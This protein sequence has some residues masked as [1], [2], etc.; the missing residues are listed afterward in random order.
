[1]Y[2]LKPVNDVQLSETTFPLYRLPKLIDLQS[3]GEVKEVNMSSFSSPEEAADVLLGKLTKLDASLQKLEKQFGVTPGC[4]PKKVATGTY[5][6]GLKSSGPSTTV[7]GVQDIVISAN[8]AN[9]PLS[10]L[11]LAHQLSQQYKT[12]LSSYT[13]STAN[14]VNDKLRQ[15]FGS[16]SNSS[17]DRINS[18][19][20]VSIVWRNDSA[21]KWGPSLV[22]SAL[23]HTPIQGE[24]NVARYLSRL[25]SASYEDSG[26]ATATDVDSLLDL[27]SQYATGSGKDRA[28]ILRTI[29]T[30]LAGNQWLLGGSSFSLAD[31]VMWSVISQSG[32]SINVP[33]VIT[34]WLNAC[35]SQP[36][37]KLASGVL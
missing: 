24:A 27:A 6:A 31:I 13:H 28:A 5:A 23:N 3:E 17:A 14:G 15:F 10:V 9:P 26:V 12:L 30:R 18:N 21:V 22:V 37:F 1:M 7:P 8:A 34:A 19:L 11:V 16:Q 25:L 20:M 2:N 32:K 36:D 33:P 4:A 35:S 29:V